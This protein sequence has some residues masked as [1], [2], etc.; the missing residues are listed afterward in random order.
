MNLLGFRILR[1]T[2][3]NEIRR[4]ASHDGARN[5]RFTQLLIGKSN[6][7]AGLNCAK[8][9][10]VDICLRRASIGG[11]LGQW[12]TDGAGCSNDPTGEDTAV[13]P[14]IGGVEDAIHE[15]VRMAGENVDMLVSLILSMEKRQ[16]CQ[17]A[18]FRSLSRLIHAVIFGDAFRERLMH[19]R[20]DSMDGG[21]RRVTVQD[22]VKP[23]E[24]GEIELIVRG[25]IKVDEIH[26]AL[27]PVVVSSN[28]VVARIVLKALV[29]NQRRVEPI[30]ELLNELGAGLGRNRI[31]IADAEKYGHG[32][33][34]DELAL[35]EI[36]P[37]ELFV[38]NDGERLVEMFRLVLDVFVESVD[39]PEIA[40]MPVKRCVFLFDSGGDGGHD[41]VPAIARIA[42]DGKGPG[43]LSGLARGGDG[44]V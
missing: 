29:L 5:I 7:A 20:D 13:I 9:E 18:T 40:E 1:K 34:R 22:F 30:G 32:T 14:P 11:I 26:S 17:A 42:G 24:L 16:V 35:D 15:I 19:G 39:G 43:L 31:V 37:C 44:P 27:D 10:A 8:K 3:V 4:I 36:V 6:L 25:V 2:P 12:V 21:V 23:M 33:E 41:D 38:S 28:Q